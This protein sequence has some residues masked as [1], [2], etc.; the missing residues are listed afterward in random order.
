MNIIGEHRTSYSTAVAKKAE[1]KAAVEDNLAKK[2]AS[3][4]EIR[5]AFK[6]LKSRPGYTEAMGDAL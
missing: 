5:R 6:N 2:K 4:A 1:K 3:I